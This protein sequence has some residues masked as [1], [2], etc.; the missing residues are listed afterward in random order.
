MFYVIVGNVQQL[1]AWTGGQQQQIK[2]FSWNSRGNN[3]LCFI[4]IWREVFLKVAV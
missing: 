3:K 2:C 1:P 4:E